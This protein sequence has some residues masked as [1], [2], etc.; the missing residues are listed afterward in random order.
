M[1]EL[2]FEALTPGARYRLCGPGGA[3]S[4]TAG[5]DGAATAHVPIEGRVDLLLEP[6][7]SP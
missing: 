2:H 5:P 4:V 1:E 3:E 7:V 6:A